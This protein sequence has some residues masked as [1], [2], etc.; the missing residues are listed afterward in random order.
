[1]VLTRSK[2]ITFPLDNNTCNGLVQWTVACKRRSSVNSGAWLQTFDDVTG[3]KKKLRCK[4]N[5]QKKSKGKIF[6]HCK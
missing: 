2:R 4:E 6:Y 1:M 5:K 3:V